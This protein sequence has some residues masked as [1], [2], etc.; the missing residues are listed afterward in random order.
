MKEIVKLVFLP[1]ENFSLVIEFLDILCN[2]LKTSEIILHS[3]KKDFKKNIHHILSNNTQL[4]LTK[5]EINTLINIFSLDEPSSECSTFI[6]DASLVLMD[7]VS[8]LNDD[9]EDPQALLDDMISSL[10]SFYHD[11]ELER[12]INE[13]VADEALVEK[14]TQESTLLT[15]FEH[16][17][18]FDVFSESDKPPIENERK[19]QRI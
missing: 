3:K 12:A 11:D 4:I 5:E 1:R 7:E 10:R 14:P 13:L 8:A 19:V 2:Q 16:K 17:R 15:M 18:G 9:Q 6:N